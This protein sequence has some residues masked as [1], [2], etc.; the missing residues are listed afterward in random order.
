MMELFEQVLSKSLSV[1][2]LSLLI[3]VVRWLL[4][5]AP[6]S[7]T[8]ALWCLVALHLLLPE[9]IESPTSLLPQENPGESVVSSWMDSYV[10]DVQ[11]YHD[12]TAAYQQAVDSGRVPLPA[13]RKSVV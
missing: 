1:S 5:K 11:I 7:M 4:R 10:E 13:D 12:N 3:L 6:H 2:G 8:M 9:T